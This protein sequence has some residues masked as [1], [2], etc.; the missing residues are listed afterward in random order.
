MSRLPLFIELLLAGYAAFLVF[1]C[2]RIRAG[3]SKRQ[4]FLHIAPNLLCGW[5]RLGRSSE[6]Y[7]PFAIDETDKPFFIRQVRWFFF[8]TIMLFVMLHIGFSL[9]R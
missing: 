5:A 8:S 9:V 4:S 6:P 7:F 3:L 2:L 1:F